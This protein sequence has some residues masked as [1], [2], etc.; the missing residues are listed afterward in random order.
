[1]ILGRDGDPS[2]L[3]DHKSSHLPPLESVGSPLMYHYLLLQI[4][5]QFPQPFTQHRTTDFLHVM[6]AWDPGMLQSCTCARAHG[7]YWCPNVIVL[8]RNF[9][10]V[11]C[12]LVCRSPS[13]SLTS[14]LAYRYLS[15]LA[16]HIEL[17]SKCVQAC[18]NK[19]PWLLFHQPA[20]TSFQLRNWK[21]IGQRRW[22]SWKKSVVSHG[23]FILWIFYVMY[24]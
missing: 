5:Q 22:H 19:P 15:L 24:I 16:I 20:Q 23:H 18:M 3:A 9:I 4:C 10:K 1:M 14:S 7:L 2:Q 12:V 6:I 8:A 17:A 11:M 13:H 21:T